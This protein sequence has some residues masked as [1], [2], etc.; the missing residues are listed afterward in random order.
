MGAGPKVDWTE[1]HKPYD[2]PDSR[3]ARRLAVV[4]EHLGRALD[5]RTGPVRLISMCAGQ[6]RDVIPVLATHARRGDVTAL[7]VEWELIVADPVLHTAQGA[8][9]FH[10]VEVGRPAFAVPGGIDELIAH[11]LGPARRS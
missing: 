3:L 2:D 7:L 11:V 4:Q 9:G 1:W 6:G 10:A 8:T 5:E